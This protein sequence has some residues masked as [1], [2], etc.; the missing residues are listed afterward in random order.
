MSYDSSKAH[1]SG[2]GDN[3]ASAR[4]RQDA[5]DQK[6]RDDLAADAAAQRRRDAAVAEQRRRDQIAARRHETTYVVPGSGSQLPT[7][8]RRKRTISQAQFDELKREADAEIARNNALLSN[9]AS[10]TSLS[11]TLLSVAGVAALVVGT[12]AWNAHRAQREQ[13]DGSTNSQADPPTTAE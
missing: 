5:A 2:Y 11:K 6:R 12:A 7:T 13:G 10:R 3:V 1:W 4:A 9:Q 8:G